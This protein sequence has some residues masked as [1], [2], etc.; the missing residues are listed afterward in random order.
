MP[1]LALLLLL[2]LAINPA[3]AQNPIRRCVDAN[4]RQVFTDQPCASVQATDAVAPATPPAAPGLN[5]TVPVLCAAT[6]AE[7]RQAVVDAFATRDANRLAGLILWNGGSAGTVAD[8]QALNGLTRQPLLDF[9]EAQAD[10]TAPASDLR[11]HTGMAG[12][13]QETRFGIVRHAG[14]LWLTPPG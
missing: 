10:D 3:H 6:R 2:L 5:S 7:L 13:A 8:I 11:L 1:R 4:G 9:G 12:A 14:C